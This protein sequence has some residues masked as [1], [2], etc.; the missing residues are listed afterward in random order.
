MPAHGASG[1]RGVDAKHLQWASLLHHGVSKALLHRHGCCCRCC[2]FGRMLLSLT[3]QCTAER[4]FLRQEHP[5]AYSSRRCGHRELA[6]AWRRRP[7]ETR[8]AAHRQA[9]PSPP[10]QVVV[11]PAVVAQGTS[12]NGPPQA[13]R[14]EADK[15][16]EPRRYRR[17]LQPTV[18]SSI[19]CSHPSRD[20]A[21]AS[22]LLCRLTSLFPLADPVRSLKGCDVRKISQKVSPPC[23]LIVLCV[24]VMC[25]LHRAPSCLRNTQRR[26]CQ[27]M[28]AQQT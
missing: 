14:F 24:R 21:C 7:C 2:A 8:G 4:P 1:S 6:R 27:F 16:F 25:G 19:P 22:S 13:H 15:S 20:G 23:F 9:I 28:S 26:C 10:Q 11:I 12:R 3:A 18:S 5:S 17:R